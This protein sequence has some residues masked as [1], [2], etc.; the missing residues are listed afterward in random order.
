M[1]GVVVFIVAL[2]AGIMGGTVVSL[3]V[4]EASLNRAIKEFENYHTGYYK[5]ICKE[6]NERLEKMDD[7]HIIDIADLHN[8][9]E[10]T[11]WLDDLTIKGLNDKVDTLN[12]KVDEHFR[13]SLGVWNDV[14]VLVNPKLKKD[15]KKIEELI[16]AIPIELDD[17][18]RPMGPVEDRD[19]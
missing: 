8:D 13:W 11:I 17:D 4:G 16:N 7:H 1:N 15:A 3:I 6:L 2:V 5:N 18:L 9:I 12:R 19:A 14:S 10:K